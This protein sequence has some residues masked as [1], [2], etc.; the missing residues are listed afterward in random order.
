MVAIAGDFHVI[1]S[2]IFAVLAAILAVFLHHAVASWMSAFL[3]GGHCNESSR[4]FPVQV[5]GYHGSGRR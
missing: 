2:G 1:F 5:R 4:A 3:G